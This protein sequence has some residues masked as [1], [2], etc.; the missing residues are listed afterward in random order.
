MTESGNRRTAI[1][2]GIRFEVFKRDS[3]KCQY[4]G[5]VAPEVVLQIDHIQPVSKGGTN[6]STNLITACIACNAGKRDKTLDDRTAIVKQRVQLEELQERREQLEMLMEWQQGLKDLNKATLSQVGSYWQD[7]APG[8]VINDNGKR[9]LS[10]WL[11]QFSPEEVLHAMDVAAEQY[12]KFNEDSTVTGES[13]E[14]AFAKIPGICRVGRESE[15]D[16]EIRER[17]LNF[18]K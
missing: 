7:L 3:F 2:K 1:L 9:N 15:E 18:S 4:C 17:H 6:D 10:K 13:W 8:F 11:R 5:A 14:E 16:P 12:L